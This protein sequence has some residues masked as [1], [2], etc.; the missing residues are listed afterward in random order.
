MPSQEEIDR[1]L[2]RLRNHRAILARQLDHVAQLG[3]TQLPADIAQGI[4]D[5]R[6][7]IS[8]CK[9]QL[10]AWGVAIDDHP[11]DTS[12]LDR[13][14]PGGTAD[15]VRA[16]RAALPD[17]AS[18]EAPDLA[19]LLRGLA[20]GELSPAAVHDQLDADPALAKLLRS[21]VG[22][23]IQVG[24]SAVAFGEGS[25][26]G[27]V[28]IRDV[29]GGDIITVNVYHGA[30]AT[31][32]TPTHPQ[33][34]GQA[35]PLRIFLCHSSADKAAV[36]R[37][38][39]ILS[40]G[41]AE[42]WLDEEQLI[43][44]Q[45]WRRAI[46]TAVEQS[47][48]VLVCLSR[49]AV[50]REGYLRDEI[51]F[52]LTVAERRS[53]GEIFLIPLL[54]EPCDV[55][56]RL[57]RWHWVS[58]ADG[59]GMSRLHRALRVRA[60]ELGAIPPDLPAD[61][62]QAEPAET[63][64]PLRASPPAG[65][66]APPST[67]QPFYTRRDFLTVAGVG[68]G[69]LTLFAGWRLIAPNDQPPAAPAP[70]AGTT[71]VAQATPNRAPTTGATVAATPAGG[72]AAPTSAVA[73]TPTS[74]VAATP[75]VMS[76]TI[77]IVTSPPQPGDINWP[78]RPPFEPIAN[79]SQREQLFGKIEWVQAA[80]D[81]IRITNGWDTE[82]IVDVTIPQ[83]AGIPGGGDGII[84]FHRLAANQLQRLWATWEAA[85]LLDR[86]LTFDGAWVPRTIRGSPDIL[87]VHSYGTEL[88]MNA[89][90]NGFMQVPAL[91]GQEGSVR[92]LVPIAN[93]LGFWW[94][95]HSDFGGGAA[96]GMAFGIARILA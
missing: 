54:L 82:N 3:S 63:P 95:G 52:V 64:A 70:T 10:H 16:L 33:A 43:A 96:D 27:D 57:A 62:W 94:Y 7:G 78:P 46:P 4:A 79:N 38:A 1:Q 32:R 90:W 30:P 15:V 41:G 23:E 92:E 29:A 75:P 69:A 58:L 67:A 89:R 35:R 56:D 71:P 6:A 80:G 19:R 21:L 93:Q 2:S 87:S 48:V 49:D 12:S 59:E 37:L 77:E 5:A 39:R 9:A 74:A 81:N 66:P 47:D 18:S 65:T 31:L 14:A 60:G 20:S 84:K 17:E 34:E 88:D 53:E 28:S 51:A 86:V 50:S 24:P 45:D 68:A 85:G 11:D 25:Q 76:A 22:Q 61:A 36:R 72:S 55:P 26:V 8:A 83:L 73:A 91:V 42:P 44:G 40:A 13:A